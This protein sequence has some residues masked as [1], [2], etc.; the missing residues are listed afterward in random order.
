MVVSSSGTTVRNGSMH[1][2]HAFA[3]DNGDT[4]S[5]DTLIVDCDVFGQR[6]P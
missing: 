3:F 4:Y 6:R 1:D 5:A 2:N